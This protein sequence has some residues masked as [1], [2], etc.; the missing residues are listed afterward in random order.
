[1]RDEPEQNGS[2]DR[3]AGCGQRGAGA[4]PADAC[5]GQAEGAAGEEVPGTDVHG[6]GHIPDAP[7]VPDDEADWAQRLWEP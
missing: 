1:M 3:G 7:A 4:G 5:A 2:P 6:A